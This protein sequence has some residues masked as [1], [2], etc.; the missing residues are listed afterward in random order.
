MTHQPEK[1][2]E[3]TRYVSLILEGHII[4]VTY[5]LLTVYYLHSMFTSNMSDATL[6][7]PWLQHVNTLRYYVE[8][9]IAV[10]LLLLTI[11]LLW[12]SPYTHTREF[13]QMQS[14]YYLYQAWENTLLKMRIKYTGPKQIFTIKKTNHSVFSYHHCQ[15][16]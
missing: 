9:S 8:K 3:L 10:S 1:I 16:C 13:N 14:E 12:P 2:V 11:S 7:H 15:E 5:Q 4:F 6:P